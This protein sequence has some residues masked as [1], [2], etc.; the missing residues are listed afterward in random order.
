M[1]VSDVLG[2]IDNT[3]VRWGKS[4]VRKKYLLNSQGIPFAMVK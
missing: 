2:I 1:K 3:K 4:H